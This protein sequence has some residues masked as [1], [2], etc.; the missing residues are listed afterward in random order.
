MLCHYIMGAINADGSIW[1]LLT[2]QCGQHRRSLTPRTA[3]LQISYRDGGLV[4][5]RSVPLLDPEGWLGEHQLGGLAGIFFLRCGLE[6]SHQGTAH[7]FLVLF[8]SSVLGP[9]DLPSQPRSEF[10]ISNNSKRAWRN[11]SRNGFLKVL[12]QLFHV[13]LIFKFCSDLGAV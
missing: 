4:G 10:C 9:D 11:G 6:P 2:V 8:A 12:Q 7:S 13:H 1:H 5:P 3:V